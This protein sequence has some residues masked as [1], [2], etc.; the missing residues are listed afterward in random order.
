MTDEIDQAKQALSECRD[1]IHDLLK[2][3]DKKT[4]AQR[5]KSVEHI[6]RDFQLLEEELQEQSWPRRLSVLEYLFLDS[7]LATLAL[8]VLF[9]L[10]SA[11]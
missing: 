7:I 9:K 5:M 10:I 6:S 3:W 4:Y 1:E 11:C 8:H 2:S